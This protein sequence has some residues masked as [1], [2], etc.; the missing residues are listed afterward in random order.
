[1]RRSFLLSAFHRRARRRRSGR[2]GWLLAR[3]ARARRPVLPARGERRLRRQALLPEDRLGPGDEPD[4]LDRRHHGEGD[5]GSLALRPRPA[6]ILDPAP[7]RERRAGLVPASRPGARDHAAPRA[8]RRPLLHGRRRLRGRAVD[9]RRPRRGARGLGAD[10]GRRVRRRRAAGLARLVPGERHAARQG[11]VRLQGHRAARAHRARER[12]PRGQGHA[13]RQDDV[14][15][16]RGRPDGP[17]P[18]HG[19]GRRVR[20]EDL[21]RGPDPELRRGR[22]DARPAARAGQD[23]GRSSGSSSGST[24]AIRS[25][26]SARSSTTRPMSATR[27]RRRRS[28]CSTRRRTRRRSSTS[29]RTCG[30]ATRSRSRSGRTSGCTRASRP[31]RSGSG[32]SA[33][34]ATRR[35]TSSTSC[36]RRPR[37][38]RSSGRRRRA[39]RAGRSSSSTGRSTT[40]AA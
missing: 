4:A 8:A 38:T 12:R 9:R 3:L 24:G 25:T 40:A 20:P 39:T 7:H 1:M 19:D 30:S 37:P 15:L 26:R 33:R 17:V 5:A 36:T 28:R 6:R 29:S 16:G 35:P 14:G 11:D 2:R 21:A 27:S 31:G 23:P 13:R 32:A 10:R 34:A 18:R 22:P